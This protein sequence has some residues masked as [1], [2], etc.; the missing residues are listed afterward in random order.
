MPP[1][2]R[3]SQLMVLDK[4]QDRGKILQLK[5]EVMAQCEDAQAAIT[6]MVESEK[7]A[8]NKNIQKRM[9]T[10]E[11]EF[12]AIVNNPAVTQEERKEITMEAKRVV[13]AGRG[14]VSSAATP[15]LFD[16]DE[17]DDWC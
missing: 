8:F 6:A 1:M 9:D 4:D 10:I 15:P 13:E 16:A 5:G 7:K 2:G 11:K 17:L 12:G 14:A 3:L